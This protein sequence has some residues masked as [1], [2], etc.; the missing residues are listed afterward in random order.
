MAKQHF[1]EVSFTRFKAFKTF[2]LSLRHFNILVGPNNAGKSTIL[3]SFRILAAGLRAARSRKPKLLYGPNGPTLGYVIDLTSLSVAEENIFHNYDDEYAATVIFKLSDRS[4]LTLYFPEQGS[5]YLIVDSPL[6]SVTRPAEFRDFFDCEIGFVPILG[7]V[8]HDERLFESEAA[9]LA[10]FSYHAARN[11]RNIWHHFPEHF[12]KFR[13]VLRR[14]WPGMDIEPPEVDASHKRPLLRMF[15]PEERI[16]RELFWSGFGFQ[17]WCQMLTHVI[18]NDGASIFLIDEPDIYLHADL[19][20]QLVSILRDL[21]PDILIA[22]HSTEIVS[23]AD[24]HDIVVINKKSSS[25]RRIKDPTQLGHVFSLLGS[26]LNPVLTQLAKTKR[27]LFVEGTDFQVIGRFASKLGYPTVGNRSDFAVVP[28][29]GFNPERMKNLKAGMEATLGMKIRSAIILDRDFRSDVQCAAYASEC[30]AECDVVVIH[31]R[32]EIENFL[33]IPN[34]IDRAAT[35]RLADRDKRT[36]NISVYDQSAREILSKFA[37][38]Q[39]SYVG[40]QFTSTYKNFIRLTDKKTHEATLNEQALAAF[41]IM[42]GDLPQRLMLIG[43][44]SALSDLSGHLQESCSISLTPTAIIDAMFV[45]EIPQEMVDL[46]RQ[47]DA[48]AKLPPY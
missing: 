6:G 4:T 5:S 14:T 27:V 24:T 2:K 31:K 8:E 45:S 11:F 20:R 3:A 48:F 13:E 18:Q 25:S 46:V 39:K 36:H 44:K 35:K 15:C 47:L 16:P 30:A 42:W 19:Q 1:L 38:L 7:P 33:L 29:D 28:L 37:K 26:N 32:K 23:E 10:L 12:L 41:D 40:G 22:T 34:A 17:V 43:G 9:R 21:G